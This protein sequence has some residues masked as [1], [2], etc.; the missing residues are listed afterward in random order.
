MQTA[1]IG[2]GT[3]N[4][5]F[6]VMPPWCLNRQKLQYSILLLVEKDLVI[7]DRVTV[8]SNLQLWDGLRMGGDV[9]T[10][11]TSRFLTRGIPKVAMS[12]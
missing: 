6:A 3:C 7:G 5:Q 9:V 8:T 10:A 2:V 11:P 12:I 4:C 1:A